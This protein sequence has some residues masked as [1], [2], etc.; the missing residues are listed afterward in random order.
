VIEMLS[1]PDASSPAASHSRRKDVHAELLEVEDPAWGPC[2]N[3]T[4]PGIL[5]L[6]QPAAQD[7]LQ[8]PMYLLRFTVL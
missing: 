7:R 8:L 1:V 6:Q 3:T 4:L 2:G 5:A